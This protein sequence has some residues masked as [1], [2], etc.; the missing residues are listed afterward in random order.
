MA[1]RRRLPPD[2]RPRWDDPDLRMLIGRH[3]YTP[4]AL[5]YECETHMRMKT[6]KHPHWKDD[7]TYDLRHRRTKA[8]P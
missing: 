8:V 1:R 5:M 6:P 2:T 3:W 4:V 7:P